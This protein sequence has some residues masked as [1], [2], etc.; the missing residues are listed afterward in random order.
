[1]VPN[2]FPDHNS[3]QKAIYAIAMYCEID[4][5]SYLLRY[6][7]VHFQPKTGEIT[8]QADEIR[9]LDPAS[10]KNNDILK[11]EAA[12]N[13]DILKNKAAENSE[14]RT[15][16]SWESC[17]DKKFVCRFC[18]MHFSTRDRIRRHYKTHSKLLS[19]CSQQ[20]KKHCKIKLDRWD[21]KLN[22]TGA[23][24]GVV[25]SADRVVVDEGNINYYVAYQPKCHKSDLEVTK[26]NKK[27]KY[28]KR[29][30]YDSSSEDEVLKKPQKKKNKFRISS[31]SSSN[32]T[33]VIDGNKITTDAVE[34]EADIINYG[35]DT[36]PESQK[37]GSC[38]PCINIDDSSNDA[39]DSTER[40]RQSKENGQT[41]HNLK[42]IQAIT[43]MCYSKFINSNCSNE[44]QIEKTKKDAHLEES[45]NRKLLS[46]GRKVMST[47]GIPSPGL[48]KYLQHK[49]LAV[50]WF[51]NLKPSNS[52]MRQANYIRIMTKLEVPA[53]P[54]NGWTP[55]MMNE[56]LTETKEAV[57]NE[58]QA[59]VSNVISES[60]IPRKKMTC[61]GVENLFAV[62]LY[63]LPSQETETT[64]NKLLNANPVANPKTLP[65]KTACQES[66]SDLKKQMSKSACDSISIES[67]E[68]STPPSTDLS[69][70]IIMST[71]SLADLAPKE[72]ST[73]NASA[74]NT[75][76]SNIAN[77]ERPLPRIKCKPVAELMAPGKLNGQ[78][79]V[80]SVMI[81]LPSQT[82]PGQALA[83]QALPSEALT[84]L[85]H[86]SQA[87]PSLQATKNT[88][89]QSHIATLPQPA[90]THSSRQAPV[91]HF[92]TPNIGNE[93][94]HITM[95]SID[96]P[97]TSTTRPMEYCK[98]LLKMHDLIL[99][100]EQN[101][102]LDKTFVSLV[103]FKLD[104]SR[105]DKSV[106]VG[107]SL[108]ARNNIFCVKLRKISGEEMNIDILPTFW[109]MHILKSFVG[110]VSDKIVN[111]A[112]RVSHASYTYAKKF[113]C[114]LKSIEYK[115]HIQ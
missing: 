34:D 57:N 54:L 11:D 5:N 25:L 47:Q 27:K 115:S 4:C 43:A 104:I 66:K 39:S 50:N 78:E 7:I 29:I 38:E 63:P 87:L 14:Q 67:D 81:L 110:E 95:N 113:V 82:P 56:D 59:N 76:N 20:I 9:I 107:L 74:T 90:S 108:Y 89:L 72:N 60:N 21:E 71:T 100:T 48:L 93:S 53:N 51:P 80:K 18:K 32:E 6:V 101:Y 44:V 96:L 68:D 52:L 1:M 42:E 12:E 17:F 106:I 79:R 2:C 62:T 36:I 55:V 19:T 65:K 105:Q 83:N 75:E 85:V 28:S 46:I 24:Q 88:G 98:S 16:N 23:F 61:S 112:T 91:P 70:P 64:K 40:H 37:G 58:N 22:F 8:T 45:L 97:N 49:N 103:K 102:Q 84:S 86:P 15:E 41:N 92:E 33:I 13:D 73:Y 114:L 109:Q 31:R 69:L 26:T 30:L 77:A 111:C 35:T 10:A 3:S 94:E 99:I